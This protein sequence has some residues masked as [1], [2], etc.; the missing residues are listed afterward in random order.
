MKGFSRLAITLA[1]LVPLSMQSSKLPLPKMSPFFS[2][3]HQL[4]F[5][6]FKCRLEGSR[7]IRAFPNVPDQLQKFI[8]GINQFRSSCKCF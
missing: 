4:L 8:L 2:K 1:N 7:T 6:Q 3:R 5:F